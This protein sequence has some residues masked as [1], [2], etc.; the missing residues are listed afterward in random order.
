MSAFDKVI[1]YRSAKEELSQI[2]DMFKNSEVYKDMG[3]KL[4]HGVL[5]YGAPG[6]GKTLLATSFIEE[7][8][9]K[10]YVVKSTKGKNA[11]LKDISDAFESAKQDDKAIIF[12]DDMDKFSSSQGRDV[13]DPIFVAIQSGIDSVKDKDIL[14]IAT[15]NNIDK[16]PSSLRR[17]GRFD[18]KLRISTPGRKDAAKIVEYYLRKR[19]VDPN[20]NYDDIAK[21]INYSSCADLD[22]V[23]NKGAIIAAYKRKPCVQTEDIVEAYLGDTYDLDDWEEK[24]VEERR[25]TSLHEAGHCVVCEVIKKGSVGLVSV[26]TR[27]GFTKRCL[28]LTRRPQQVLISLAGKV[29]CELYDKGRVASGCYYDLKNATQL[30]KDGLTASGTNGTALLYPGDSSVHSLSDAY[31]DR[32]IGAINT[33]LERYLFLVRDIL[34]KNKDFL[35][36]LRDELVEKGTLLHSDI[37]RI[38]SSFEVTPCE[39]SEKDEELSDDRGEP[40]RNERGAMG[41]LDYD[42]EDDY[43]Y[44]EDDDC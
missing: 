36:A 33:E 31:K 3:A 9:V 24:S 41:P 43:G 28:A 15:V 8:G 1:G 14:V 26:R 16:L 12:F 21:M 20:A 11:I 44:L 17:N 39:Y 34:I 27:D 42:D 2:L 37:Q 38:R 22:K 7:A 5:L 6:M 13:D 25:S 29:A 18:C 19:K 35:F 10:T 30:I 23:V 4:P 32:V 40:E